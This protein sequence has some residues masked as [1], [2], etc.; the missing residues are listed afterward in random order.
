[1]L[2]FRHLQFL[3]F[4]MIS[5]Q[6]GALLIATTLVAVVLWDRDLGGK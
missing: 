5:T 2:R 3:N 4:G 1:M 6:W